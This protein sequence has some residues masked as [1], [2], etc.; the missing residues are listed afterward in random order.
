MDKKYELLQDDTI[1]VDGNTLY[2]IRA[3]RDFGNVKAGEVGGYI[4]HERNLSHA[5][6]CWLYGN[7]KAYDCARVNGGARLYDDAQASGS[8]LISTHAMMQ[9]NS[10][11]KGNAIIRGMVNIRGNSIIDGCAVL[12]DHVIVRG[13]SVVRGDTWLHGNCVIDNGYIPNGD[14]VVW[15]SNVGND[16]GTLT[17]YCGKTELMATRGCFA[18]TLDVFCIMNANRPFSMNSKRFTREYELLVEM[19]RLRLSK[20]QEDILR[21]AEK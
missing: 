14:A 16:R 2:R 1:T 20:S 3:L 21:S 15:F 19:A 7:S 17:V 4:E 8:V 11:A 10:V 12:Y 18:D 9:G 6:D 5:G 13:N